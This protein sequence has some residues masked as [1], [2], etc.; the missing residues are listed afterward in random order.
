MPGTILRRFTC[1]LKRKQIPRQ[2]RPALIET[3]LRA[4]E[5][6]GIRRKTAQR[7][8]CAGR[9]FDGY[10]EIRWRNFTMV[11]PQEFPLERLS[12]IIVELVA[13]ANPHY[14]FHREIVIND[15]DLVIDVGACEGLFS[16]LAAERWPRARILAVE[17]S[18][19]M[20]VGLAQA[21]EKGGLKDRVVIENCLLGEYT[22]NFRFLENPADPATS[23]VLA[24]DET[25][26]FGQ[27]IVSVPMRK[28][29]DIDVVR[30]A[31]VALI[32]MDAEGYEL[33]ILKGCREIIVRDKPALCLTT[34]H[35]RDDAFNIYA[36][37]T[38]LD[39]GYHMEVRGITC[40]DSVDPRPMMLFALPPGRAATPPGPRRE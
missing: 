8:I 4:F 20:C 10:R 17:P 33:E 22:G 27:K 28:L 34:Y 13:P 18:S 12:S 38:S 36:W 23:R 31:R 19:V 35:N 26:E 30:S 32:K 6:Y 37:L 3:V 1:I 40:M 2:V 16:L 29:D 24:P 9:S 25:A 14:F 39:L 7:E 21:V 11:L 5:W 15:R